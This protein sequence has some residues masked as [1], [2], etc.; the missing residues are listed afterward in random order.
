[1][2]KINL[3]LDID[4]TLLTTYDFNFYKNKSTDIVNPINSRISII[5]LPNYI[6]LVYL[7]PYLFKF[8]KYCFTFFNVSFWTAGSTLYCREILKIILTE[9]QYNKVDVI[10]ARDNNNYVDIKTNK[11]YKNIIK[12]DKIIKPLDLLWN[13]NILSQ[14]FNN[15]NTLLID[16]N[17]NIIINNPKN[18]IIIKEYNYTESQ[19]IILCC[20]SNWLDIIKDEPDITIV[21][22]NILNVSHNC[23]KLLKFK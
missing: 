10:L 19:D 1:M 23:K 18:S 15:K 21:K 3:I 20:L 9:E 7:R 5:Q 16:N 2:Q 14:R 13:D 4:E 12:S 17:Y 8:L 22:K 6:G 11:I